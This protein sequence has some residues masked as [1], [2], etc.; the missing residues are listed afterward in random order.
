VGLNAA[1]V[2]ALLEDGN[3]AVFYVALG[4]GPTAAD[5]VSAARTL[6]TSGV[7]SAVITATSVPY[8]YTGTPDAVATHVLIFS[9]STG[10]T[11]YGYDVLSGDQAIG[12]A[13]TYNLTA[14][15]IAGAAG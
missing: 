15:T 6:L 8:A 2:T 11:F 7:A 5:Q 12:A 4:D 10:G 14:L 13:G 9:A 1:G 3:E